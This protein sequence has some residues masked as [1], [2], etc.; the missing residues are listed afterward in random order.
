[1]VTAEATCDA[2]R[3]RTK[4]SE[5]V[6]GGVDR[7]GLDRQVGFHVMGLFAAGAIV[8]YPVPDNTVTQAWCL[9]HTAFVLFSLLT[10]SAW[11][12]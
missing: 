1:M 11:Q 7:S 9:W 12:L 5:H 3:T 6:T 8:A 4:V 2:E 10:A